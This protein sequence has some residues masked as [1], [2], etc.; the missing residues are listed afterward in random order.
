MVKL[1]YQGMLGNRLWQYAVARCYAERN[2]HELVNDPIGGFPETYKK[3]DGKKEIGNIKRFSDYLVDFDSHNGDAYFF[4]YFQRYENIKKRKNDIK[5]WFKMECK[6]PI[7][8]EKND[9]VM[10]I[11]RGAFGFPVS[12]TPNYQFYDDFISKNR[13][14]KIIL[15]TCSFHDEYFN[16]L[17]KYSNVVYANYNEIE[18]FSIIRSANNIIMSP[19]TF[20]WWGAFLSEA[21]K[22]Y[23]P[24]YTDFLPSVDRQNM[25]VDDENRYKYINV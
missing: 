8:V 22:I 21:E 10:H 3:V 9:L 16:F 23:Y 20:S 11:R 1:D 4:G 12:V 7:R 18:T 25:I 13:Y 19:S 15:C 5:K 24:M 14:N 2:G 6:S 17:K